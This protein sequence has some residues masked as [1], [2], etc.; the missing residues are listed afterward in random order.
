MWYVSPWRWS[1]N[2]APVVVFKPTQV[3]FAIAY[4]VWRDSCY[5]TFTIRLTLRGVS[6]SKCSCSLGAPARCLFHLLQQPVVWH[7]NKGEKTGNSH[8][9]L[10]SLIPGLLLRSLWDSISIRWL[11]LA[12]EV[13]QDCWSESI[14]RG[15][16][17]QAFKA[18]TQT[19]HVVGVAP[20]LE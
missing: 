10:S 17:S 4:S 5:D 19:K 13:R 6:P 1:S 2:L 12:E 16:L 20:S 9:K 14:R 3:S 11:W 7:V 15:G 8:I 18:V